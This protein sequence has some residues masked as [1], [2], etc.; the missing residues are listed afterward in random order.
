MESNNK[1]IRAAMKFFISLFL[2]NITMLL[3]ASSHQTLEDESDGMPSPVVGETVHRV[4][5]PSRV[6][7][8]TS[9]FLRTRGSIQE[10]P[11]SALALPRRETEVILSSKRE[12]F[13]DL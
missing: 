8:L 1:E 9:D 12:F 5:E 2:I 13:S 7:G 4:F 11:K 10:F 6:V 3:P